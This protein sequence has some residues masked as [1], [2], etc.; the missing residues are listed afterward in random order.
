MISESVGEIAPS[1][2]LPG[3][4]VVAERADQSQ[5][6]HHDSLGGVAND[7]ALATK[8][9]DESGAIRLRSTRPRS[10]KYKGVSWCSRDRKWLVQITVDSK[11]VH[12]GYFRD[13]DEAARRY[14]EAALP[15]GK[16]LN[17]FN[18]SSTV[19]PAPALRAT[20]ESLICYVGEG[21]HV[22]SSSSSTSSFPSTFTPQPVNFDQH[23]LLRPCS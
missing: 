19:D 4:D 1:P 10:S 6:M 3:V 17:I 14:N 9:S 15:L 22:S 21:E 7:A 11:I 18:D 8:K 16:S 20:T 12:L 2:S 13:E 23:S 5:Q